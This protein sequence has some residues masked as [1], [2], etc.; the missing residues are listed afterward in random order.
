MAKT[1]IL[2]KEGLNTYDELIKNYI[3]DSIPSNATTS[4]D[5]L[6]SSSDK[7]KLDFTN[8]A[9]GTCSTAAATA[10]KVITINGND[11]WKLSVG[12]IIIVKFTVS[13][14]ASNVTLNVNNTGAKS[15]WYNTSVY[16]ANSNITCGCANRYTTYMYDGTYWVWVSNGVDLNNNNAANGHG[17]GTCTTASSTA[18]KV[19]TLSGYGLAVGGIVAVKFSNAITGNAT[20]NINNRGA[21]SIY[22]KGAAITTGIINAGDIG[23]FI[24]NGSQYHLLTVDSLVGSDSN[25]FYYSDSIVTPNATNA[26]WIGGGEIG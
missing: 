19:V 15:I 13:N 9:Y 11:N 1:E 4:K 16:T 14:T 24:Y 18:A 6:M 10:E 21:K 26:V 3:S 22:Y 23:V 17:Y 8:V 20:M 25:S 5:G 2:T 7:T 12:S